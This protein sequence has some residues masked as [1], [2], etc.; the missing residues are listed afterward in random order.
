[1]SHVPATNLNNLSKVRCWQDSLLRLVLSYK[2]LSKLAPGAIF[3]INIY[4]YKYSTK[5]GYL[6]SGKQ[7]LVPFNTYV[8]SAA[9][10]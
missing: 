10:S 6:W 2:P 9:P 3:Q 5:N 1:M 7:Y 8:R 4:I